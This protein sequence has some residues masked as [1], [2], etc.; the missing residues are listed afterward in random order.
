MVWGFL[1]VLIVYEGALREKGSHIHQ[2]GAQIAMTLV[3]N[4]GDI[5][6]LLCVTHVTLY[7]QPSRYLW[8]I[9]I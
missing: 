6:Q 9:I 4:A 2:A 7:G 3:T 8:A 5:Y 1:F